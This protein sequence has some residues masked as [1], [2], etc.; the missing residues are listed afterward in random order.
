MPGR[1]RV[2]ARAAVPS[3]HLSQPPHLAQLDQVVLVPRHEVADEVQLRAGWQ[4]RQQPRKDV[5]G[6]GVALLAMVLVGGGEAPSRS[7]CGGQGGT[8]WRRVWGGSQHRAAHAASA[9][10]THLALPAA[11]EAAKQH[12]VLALRLRRVSI[13]AL[14]VTRLLAL[15]LCGEGLQAAAGT[16]SE[17]VSSLGR[18]MAGRRVLQWHGRPDGGGCVER[19]KPPVAHLHRRVQHDHRGRGVPH[20][21]C[22]HDVRTGVVV[23]PPGRRE[24]GG[25]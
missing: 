18:S 19:G 22:I 16:S 24:G 5:D 6:R 3:H 25:S 14:R 4:P 11:E 13:Q 23:V 2:R 12:N 1:K 15:R 9:P 10:Q 7:G 21:Q 17:G 8:C 20:A